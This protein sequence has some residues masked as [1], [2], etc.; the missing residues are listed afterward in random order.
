[1]GGIEIGGHVMVPGLFNQPCQTDPRGGSYCDGKEQEEKVEEMWKTR[2]E[3]EEAAVKADILSSSGVQNIWQKGDST[4]KL[5]AKC[6]YGVDQ[7]AVGGSRTV[8][9]YGP[10]GCEKNE[11]YTMA[12]GD[13][14]FANVLS[15]FP[16][17][18]HCASFATRASK[19]CTSL[20]NQD[21]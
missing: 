2:E 13:V 17:L 1:M 10:A 16:S 7:P 6:I 9:K 11:N 15:V 21:T 8:C 20:T 12:P 18:L 4:V 14:K 3:D 5:E 19:I